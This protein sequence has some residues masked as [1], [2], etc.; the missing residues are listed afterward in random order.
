MEKVGGRFL[1]EL[2]REYI[3]FVHKIMTVIARCQMLRPEC[4]E[5]DFG[6]GF[7]PDPSIT[8]LPRPPS[9]I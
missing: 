1:Q 5:F 2:R 6:L 4:T 7:V 3:N 9:W 8:A